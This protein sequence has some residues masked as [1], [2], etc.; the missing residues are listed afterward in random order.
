MSRLFLRLYLGVVFVL[1]VAWLTQLALTV[2]PGDEQNAAV[3]EAA[4]G[5]T[6]RMVRLSYEQAEPQAREQTLSLIK[7]QFDYPVEVVPVQQIPISP[8]TRLETGAEM[9]YFRSQESSFIVG[10]LADPTVVLLFGPLPQIGPRIQW[11]VIVGLA[12]VLLVSATAIFVLLR[13]INRQ[14]SE[15]ETATQEFAAGKLDKR[16]NEETPGP[17]SSIVSSLNNLAEKTETLLKTQQELIQGVSHELKAPLARIQFAV[18]LLNG[19]QDPKK[20][21]QRL[22]VIH[23]GANELEDMVN[24]L[25][26][27]VRTDAPR[28]SAT[29]WRVPL[30]PVVQQ[31]FEGERLL[32]PNLKYELDPRM[33]TDD[34]AI[35]SNVNDLT[36]VF[37]NTVRNASRF[38]RQQ[39]LVVAYR[40]ANGIIVDVEDDGPGVPEKNREAVF[41]PFERLADDRGSAG[42]GLALVGRIL[43]KHGGWAKVE[44]SS[45]G[46]CRLRTFWPKAAPAERLSS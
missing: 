42:L 27:Y 10:R 24:R 20:I 39:I 36:C 38:A 8:Q 40:T 34:I 5:G 33:V 11:T 17:L 18:E 1:F 3:I 26:Q 25:L 45:L 16:I 9:A 43:K 2:P 15:I 35:L 19:E 30:E 28:S 31:I 4:L 41:R 13:P 32:H 46:G 22:A 14:L 23:T 21:E 44:T 6:V 12:V 37:S 7:E 29:N